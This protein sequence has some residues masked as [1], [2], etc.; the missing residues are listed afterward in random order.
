MIRARRDAPFC[1]TPGR[2]PA[3]AA[4]ALCLWAAGARA[5]IKP[6]IAFDTGG[7]Q[8]KSF[9]ESVYD[10]ARRFTAET[11]VE[12]RYQ[13]SGADRDQAVVLRSMAEAGVD[14]V[15]AVGY[16]YTQ[17]VTAVA[18]LFPRTR[19]VLID[20]VARAPNVQSV[21]FRE[22]EGAYL[23]G[24]LAALRSRT[25]ILGF[26]GGQ[27]LPVIRRFACGFQA[28]AQRVGPD[29]RVLGATISNGPD[30]W[31]DLA[32]ARALARAQI[33]QGAD[34][35]FAAAGQAG[36]AVLD[37]AAAAG[38]LGIGVDKNQD[39]RHPGQ[40]LT[41]EL[42]RVDLV[43]YDALMAAR[44]GTWSAGI[45]VRTVADGGVGWALDDNNR[46]L[47]TPAMQDTVARLTA[48]LAAGH[49]G[50]S[51]D[52]DPGHCLAGTAVR[53]QAP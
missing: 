11:G 12:F 40:V 30:A 24:A 5:E 47:I 16:D 28:G 23:V 45:T 27:D 50:L 21:L 41:S 29:I 26:I 39:D 34:V 37:A 36:L 42:K 43:A 32:T 35:L 53:A 19:F 14:P 25:R 3:L 7:I 51:L 22:Q 10:G 9:N 2:A 15:I 31:R 44:A 33:A 18:P 46:A 48:D 13:V 20:G 8:D 38:V 17:A 52:E 6:G 4:A 1:R 49:G